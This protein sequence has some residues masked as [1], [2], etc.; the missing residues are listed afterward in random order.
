[1]WSS[2]RNPQRNP[3]PSATIPNYSYVYPED[4]LVS[5]FGQVLY[6]LKDKYL[7]NATLRTDGSSK[8]GKGNKW[9]VF[10]AVA[11]A[12]RMSDENFL[13]DV[14]WLS[15]LKTRLSFGTAGNNRI[16]SG[17]TSV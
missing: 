3:K 14:K 6:T 2:P 5:F 7:L 15:N 12:W 10:P 1:M 8:F 11:V 13:R 4:R 17:L 16:S 9:G